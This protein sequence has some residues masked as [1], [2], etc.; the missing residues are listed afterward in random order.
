MT[1]GADWA[2]DLPGV[3][4]RTHD[5][6]ELPAQQ[7]RRDPAA[8][9]RPFRPL[10]RHRRPDQRQDRPD[11]RASPTASG[12][13]RT[14]S[15]SAATRSTR[16][17]AAGGPM[18]RSAI[19]GSTATSIRRS[20]ICATARRSGSAAGSASPATGRSSA[21]RS[22]T[23]PASRRIRCRMADGFEPIRHRLG[24]L[25]DDDCIEL[26]LTWRRDYE[27]SRR[28]PAREHLPDPG[29]A[30]EFGPL[31]KPPCDAAKLRFSK[32][33]AGQRPA[34]TGGMMK[35]GRLARA[36]IVLI[37]PMLSAVAAAQGGGSRHGRRGL[38]IPG[39]VQFV[40][41]AGARRPQGDGDRQRRRHHRQRRR[42]ARWR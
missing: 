16:R 34:F 42:P 29:G 2:L 39:N 23:S 30:E 9:H 37:A 8:G 5:R 21:R 25:Y 33:D 22:S 1:Y 26:G 24:I 4:V 3:S 14:A 28:R 17:S 40:G 41:Q 11:G 20:R 15:R 19:C 6:P 35:L 10:L 13:T 27:T 32:F 12:S 18:R 38:N 31:R 7:P 36:A